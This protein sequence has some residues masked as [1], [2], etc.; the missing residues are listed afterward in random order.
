MEET[1][2]VVVWGTPGAQRAAMT[3]LR[4]GASLRLSCRGWRGRLLAGFLPRWFDKNSKLQFRDLLV[5][6][7]LLRV[8]SVCTFGYSTGRAVSMRIEE[9]AFVVSVAGRRGAQ[10]Q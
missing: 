10:L 1:E 7:L 4:Q 6:T 2:V 9:D 3:A 8:I 5:Q